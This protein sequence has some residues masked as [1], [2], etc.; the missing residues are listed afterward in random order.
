MKNNIRKKIRDKSARV[1]NKLMQQNSNFLFRKI[2]KTSPIITNRE[3]D[4]ILYC[5]LERTSCR[6]F[7][8]AAKSFLKYYSNIAVVVQ[9]D[10]TF[11]EKYI[12]EIRKHIDGVIVYKK[13][14]MMKML[15]EKIDKRLFKLLPGME[16]YES[17]T[18]VKIMYLKFLNVIF[19][20][21]GKKVVIMDSDLLFLRRPDEIIKWII[22]PY[23]YDFYGEGS[24]AK[25]DSFYKMGFDFRSLDIANFSSGILGIGGQ[26]N[27]DG[28]IDIFKRITDY[29]PSLFEA[30]EIEQALWSIIMSQR[31]KPINLDNLRD[32]YIGSGW[33]TYKELREKAIIA[34]FA[35]AF[36]FKNLRYIRC[37]ND[38]IKQL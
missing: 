2:L 20:F 31:D 29:D 36:R 13:S 25:S 33:R 35:G 16:M 26:V 27:Q 7:I 21:N 34:H 38:V 1:Y 19:R 12:S 37:A 9:D 14:D 22:E 23:H 4:T 10:G 24:N 15:R 17:N 28:L 32:V 5:A 6:A 3:A 30:W 8:L 18:S 11:N